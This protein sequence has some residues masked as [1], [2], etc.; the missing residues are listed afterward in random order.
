MRKLNQLKSQ[1]V[2]QSKMAAVGEL[3]AGIMHDIRN[4][5]T[6]INSYNNAFL[7]NAIEQNDTELM[8]KCQSSIEKAAERIQR[9]SDHMRS[10]TRNESEP[11]AE[12][13]LEELVNDCLLMLETKI[14]YTGTSLINNIRGKGIRLKCY[15]NKLEQ[16]IINLISNA[17]DAVERLEDGVVIV[18]ATNN[19]NNVAITV[20]DTGPGISDE[21]KAKIFESF[22]TTKIKGK[23]TGLGLSISQG[24]IYKMGG[25]ITL[26]SKADEGAVFTVSLPKR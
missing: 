2:Q 25:A 13:S 12:I 9:L 7:K 22:F 23:G 5:L 3:A 18:D 26:Q 15:P 19:P 24:I 1:L 6:V 17:C 21:N 10:F 16:V 4:P 20:S 14:K 8:L 11:L